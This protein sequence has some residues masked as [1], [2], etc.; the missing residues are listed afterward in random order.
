MNKA[1]LCLLIVGLLQMAGD[2]LHVPVL[3]AIGAATVASP[4]PKVF[5]AVRGLETYSSRFFLEWTDRSGEQHSVQLTPE[6][7]ARLAGP[8]NRRNVYGAALAYGPVLVTDPRTQP[9]FRSVISYALCGKAPLLNELGIVP[10]NVAGPV[11]V[12][13]EP[14]EGTDTQD[15]PLTLE[16]PCH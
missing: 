6:M 9:M 4:A 13:L 12:R 14:R 8:Y 11:R 10:T 3:K 7:Y 1:A 16:A 2:V 5:S 15:L